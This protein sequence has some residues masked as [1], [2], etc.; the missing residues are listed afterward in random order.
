MARATR[1]AGRGRN[2]LTS[3]FRPLV[4]AAVLVGIVRGVEHVW[5][6][7]RGV[8][9]AQEHTT[10]ARLVHATLLTQALRLARRFGLPDD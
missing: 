7:V 5:E 8:R 4:G 10:V 3:A 9:P 6:R 2:G 1:K